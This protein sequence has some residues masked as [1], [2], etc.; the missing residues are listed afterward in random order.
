MKVDVVEYL[1]VERLGAALKQQARQLV[2]LWM[3][4]RSSSPS[5]MT[6]VSGE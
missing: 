6:P 1:T 2:A 4:R 5:P 3:R